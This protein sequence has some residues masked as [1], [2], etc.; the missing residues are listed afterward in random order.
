MATQMSK[1]QLIEKIATTTEV[2]KKEVKGVMEA[3]VR[4]CALQQRRDQPHRLPFNERRVGHLQAVN[5][6]VARSPERR[7]V[8]RLPGL[9]DWGRFGN[10][11][12][13]AVE[14][15]RSACREAVIEPQSLHGF[16]EFMGRYIAR[17]SP[18]RAKEMH[19][20]DDYWPGMLA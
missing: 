4:G 12:R 20:R 11:Q 2:S 7:D 16:G 18:T 15:D 13:L 8:A 1:S 19:C 10:H 3:L 9:S 5:P 6:F 14:H 17:H